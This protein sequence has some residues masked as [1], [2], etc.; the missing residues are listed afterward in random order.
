MCICTHSCDCTCRNEEARGQPWLS[1]FRKLCALSFNVKFL[2]LGPS[3]GWL[4][5]LPC[6][7]SALPLSIPST[8]S[9]AGAQLSHG[10]WRWNSLPLTLPALPAEL[11]PTPSL[12]MLIS[13]SFMSVFIC[14][15]V[16]ETSSHRSQTSL[17]CLSRPCT[18]VALPLPLPGQCWAYSC[19]PPRANSFLALVLSFS[20]SVRS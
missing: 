14:L 6:S 1:L 16:F 20:Q 4:P 17:K 8:A 15:F 2:S 7:A 18:P 11:L 10:F 19:E 13:P 12:S 3:T 5:R 9:H